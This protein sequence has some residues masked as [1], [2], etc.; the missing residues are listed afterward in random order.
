VL[1]QSFQELLHDH[2]ICN[3]IVNIPRSCN[4]S[5]HEITKLALSWDLGQSN[6][7]KDPLSEFINSLVTHDIVEST[8]INERP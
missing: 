4:L 6:V 8:S 2:F 5:A 7:W 3:K 1:F